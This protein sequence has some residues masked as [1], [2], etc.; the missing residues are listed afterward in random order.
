MSKEV[1]KVLR[2]GLRD[3]AAHDSGKENTEGLEG[4][5]VGIWNIEIHQGSSRMLWKSHPTTESQLLIYETICLMHFT[6]SLW[7]SKCESILETI[8]HT[9]VKN[10]SVIR[11]DG[12]TR[13]L[14]YVEPTA[15]T[16]S[17]ANVLFLCFW[18]S[19]GLVRL[20]Q[21]LLHFLFGDGISSSQTVTH[22]PSDRPVTAPPHPPRVSSVNPA[23]VSITEFACEKLPP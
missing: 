16:S 19:L 18:I 6:T 17:L 5:L 22:K 9:E 11:S 21:M 15:K 2:P 4:A 7:G 1:V 13:P 8:G 3:G 10:M 12:F 14:G 20:P 23:T